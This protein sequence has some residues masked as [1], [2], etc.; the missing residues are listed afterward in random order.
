MPSG[1]TF[2]FSSDASQVADL[3]GEIVRKGM[4]TEAAKALNKSV[5]FVRDEVSA[6]VSRQIGIS[7]P[8]LKRRVKRIKSQR[9]SPRNLRTA[10]FVG[11]QSIPVSKLKPAPRKAGRGVTYKSIT[12][13]PNDPNAFHA[14]LKSG[15]KTAWV[16]KTRARGSLEE[17]HIRIGP[18]LRRSTRRIMRT[19]AQKYFEKTLF[20]NL[21]N[22]INKNIAKR[23]LVRK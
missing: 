14:M 18:H 16:R 17:K 15:K 8:L 11:E 1:I 10:G 5:T 2:S 9:A 7:R 13:Q 12:G 20:E 19:P 23:G 3:L 22:R 21:E 4:P 6:E